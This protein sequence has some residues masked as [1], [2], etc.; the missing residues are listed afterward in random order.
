MPRFLF[1]RHAQS[2][3]NAIRK[4]LDQ[5]WNGSVAHIRPLEARQRRPDPGLTKDGVRQAQNL[6]R[7]L[8]QMCVGRTL[9][10]CSPFLRTLL[11][12]EPSLEQLNPRVDV[13][14]LC[15]GLLYELGGCYHMSKTYSGLS[16]EEIARWISVQKCVHIDG[17]F[18]GRTHRESK[19][20][21]VL[22]VQTVVQWIRGF[23]NSDYETIVFMTHGA[24][25]ARVIRSLLSIPDEVWITHANTAYTSLLWDKDQGFLL[26]GI[27]QKSH[28]PL[29]LQSGD[30][31]GDGWWPAIYKRETVFHILD[32]L[33]QKY[34]ILYEEMKARRSYSCSKEIEERSVFF[35]HFYHHTLCAWVQYDPHTQTQYEWQHHTDEADEAF[36]RFVADICSK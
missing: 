21:Y 32:D 29:E 33:L 27:N 35:V 20:E 5:D 22:R 11:T 4:K 18:H 3:N 13:D 28:I 6:G 9:V 15:H 16:Q 7:V 36:Y 10:A 26:E 24:F 31:P 12:L 23:L 1:F 34:P 19:E 30:T 25:M 14:I 17:W 2:D 8:P